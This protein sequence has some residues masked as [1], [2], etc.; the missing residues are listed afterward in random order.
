MKR[1][2]QKPHGSVKALGTKL[3][4]S[5]GTEQ[6]ADENIGQFRN[7]DKP[8]VAKQDLDLVAPLFLLSIL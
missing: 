6:F 7:F 4:V 8:H 2:F 3:V 5:E 1:T